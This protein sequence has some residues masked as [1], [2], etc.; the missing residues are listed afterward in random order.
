M[1]SSLPARH[2]WRSGA[3]FLLVASLVSTVMVVRPRE[4]Y[5]REKSL[6]FEENLREPWVSRADAA[7]LRASRIDL[8]G[9]LLALAALVLG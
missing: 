3:I 9:F 7:R 6:A 5:Y 2:V 1:G 4:R 8:V